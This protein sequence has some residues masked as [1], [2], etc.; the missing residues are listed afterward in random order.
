MMIIAREGSLQ[1]V[2]QK[3]LILYQFTYAP[4]LELDFSNSIITLASAQ[5]IVGLAFQLFS[6]LLSANST[7]SPIIDTIKFRGYK[8]NKPIGLVSFIAQIFQVIV[9]LI[10]ATGVVYLVNK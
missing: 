5:W 3:A 6:I 10:F 9:H 1:F 4:M 7:F 2:Y 8:Q